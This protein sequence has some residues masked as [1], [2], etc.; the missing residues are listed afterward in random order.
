MRQTHYSD[1]QYYYTQKWSKG[2]CMQS[3]SDY[4]PFGVLLDGRSMQKMGYRYGFNSMEKDDEVKGAGNSCDFGARMYDSRIGRWLSI[5]ELTG[6][7]PGMSCFSFVGGNPIRAIDPNGKEIIITESL[8]K[9]TGKSMIKIELVG[10]VVF[11]FLTTTKSLKEK[12]I[13][14]DNLNTKLMEFY[15]QS[16]EN[17]DVV[18]ISN[19]KIGTKEDI[20]ERDH[21]IYS[22]NLHTGIESNGFDKNIGGFV[23]GIGSKKAFFS[24]NIY[25][26]STPIHEIGHW[27]GLFHPKDIAD[28]LSNYGITNSI[29]WEDKKFNYNEVFELFSGANFMHHHGDTKSAGIKE[30]T[31][32]EIQ[33]EIIQGVNSIKGLNQGTNKKAGNLKQELENSPRNSRAEQKNNVIVSKK[34]DNN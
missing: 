31:F 24:F 22:M 26:Y 25:D 5:D 10:K 1:N 13:Y 16:F 18:F 34:L 28:N 9:E 15:S 12:Q 2:V 30:P 29:T 7:Y 14:I 27:L 19:M 8:N 33:V 21:V 17:M 32:D 11:D 3:A 6:K 4:S 20:E 23:T